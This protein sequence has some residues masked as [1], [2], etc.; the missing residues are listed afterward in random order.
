MWKILKRR[1]YLL[2]SVVFDNLRQRGKTNRIFQ[3][4]ASLYPRSLMAY[5][6]MGWAY[7]QRDKYT[8]A[9]PSLS[10]HYK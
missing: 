8:E 9:I 10:V 3:R 4:I 6:W 7:L 1:W 5:T 2:V